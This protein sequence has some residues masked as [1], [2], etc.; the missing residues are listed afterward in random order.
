MEIPRFDLSLYVD[1]FHSE[2]NLAITTLCGDVTRALKEFGAILVEVPRF[3]ENINHEFVTTLQTFFSNLGRVQHPLV[4]RGLGLP[5][6]TFSSLIDMGQHVF[7]PNGCNLGTLGHNIT[8][9][10]PYHYN[11]N[12][13]TI[14]G[15]SRFHDMKTDRV[16]DRWK[17]QSSNAGG[18]CN[19]Q[20]HCYTQCSKRATS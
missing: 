15:R 1:S 11:S 17:L 7:F 2:D 16:V 18:Y 4:E 5:K 20:N 12:F 3:L 8:V 10:A 19:R 14:Q 13:L 6:K 9:L